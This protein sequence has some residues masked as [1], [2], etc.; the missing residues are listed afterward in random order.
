L[1][2]LIEITAG[3]IFFTAFCRSADGLR[4]GLGLGDG[5]G[6][7]VNDGDAVADGAELGV[8]TAGGDGELIGEGGVAIPVIWPGFRPHQDIA[9]M[10]IKTSPETKAR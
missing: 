10:T 5:V 4:L 1:K 8:V 2:T 3:S 9:I 7:G 6:E